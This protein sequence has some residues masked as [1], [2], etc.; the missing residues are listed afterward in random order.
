M[1]MYSLNSNKNR[2]AQKIQLRQFD[3]QRKNVLEIPSRNG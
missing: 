2:L 1:S 3:H